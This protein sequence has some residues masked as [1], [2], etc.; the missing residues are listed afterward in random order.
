[1]SVSNSLNTERASVMPLA[2]AKLVAQEIRLSGVYRHLSVTIV[3][4][5]PTLELYAVKVRDGEELVAKF[6][7]SNYPQGF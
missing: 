5:H 4:D 7:G 6:D 1:M 2:T 3:Q